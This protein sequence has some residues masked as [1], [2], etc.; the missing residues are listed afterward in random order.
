MI[1]TPL[2]WQE[3]DCQLADHPDQHFQHYI[4]EGLRYGFRIGFDYARANQIS[5]SVRN[6][7]STREH[8]RNITEYLAEECSLGRV[9]GPLDPNQFPQ[10]HVSRFGL[11]PKG[12]TGK[13][14]L[15]VDLSS[16]Q[17][18]SVNDGVDEVLSTLTYVV[19]EDAMR[20]IS[21]RGRG[22]IMA[23]VDIKSAY[24]NVPVHPDDRWMM[25]MLWEGALFV[26]T[27]LPF[28]LRSAPKIFTA[29]AD[30]AEWIARKEGI[31]FII[32]YLDDFLLIGAP[33]SDECA[34]AVLT[35]LEIFRRLGFP[36]AVNK[37]EGPDTMLGFLGFEL[38]TMALQIRLSENK[39]AE[40]LVLIRQWMGKKSSTKRELE[41]LVG[42]LG[43]AARVVPPG[44][45]FMRRMFELMSTARKPHHRVRLS[46]EFQ[47]D[48]AW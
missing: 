34:R 30:A 46:R 48:L 44:K 20:G 12:S 42:K 13:W 16:P 33:N 47:S 24:R 8:P 38:D 45:T 41:S 25:G 37:R 39:L 26:D 27:A 3:W 43:H 36:I 22:S 9:I 21:A 28:G 15:I 23:K 11:I 6:M 35:L 1:Q 2:C 19:I 7:P 40:L 29:L 5:S 18:L 14:R 32:H 10:V 17:G 31:D 4:V